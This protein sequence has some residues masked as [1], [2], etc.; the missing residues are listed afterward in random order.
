MSRIR[1]ATCKD[2]ET[3]REILASHGI[4]T[5]PIEHEIAGMESYVWF[6]YMVHNP[7]LTRL[8]QAGQDAIGGYVTVD[9]AI[10][11]LLDRF[12]AGQ[13]FSDFTI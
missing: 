6:Q 4:T 9:A 3:A 11:D 1:F 8:T 10:E 5:N 2:T 7:V 12:Y 13:G